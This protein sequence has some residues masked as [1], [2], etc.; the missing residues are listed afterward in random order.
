ML[1]L[2]TF[3]EMNK[4]EFINL[5]A[6]IGLFGDLSKPDEQEVKKKFTPQAV[7]S[8]IE[9]VGTFDE[10][11]LTYV[12]FLECLVRVA[13]IYQFNEQEKQGSQSVES[14]L[15]FFIQKLSERYSGLVSEFVD[16]L[17]RKEMEMN[18]QP[19]VVIDDDAPDED[20]DDM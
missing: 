11:Q 5:L 13:F 15:Q 12:D 16:A 9:S 1:H 8:A 4:E 14:K 7:I 19:K 18:Y 10:N 17:G 20:F 2:E 3:L 6:E